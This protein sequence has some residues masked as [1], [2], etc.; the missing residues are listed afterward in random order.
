MAE[1]SPA[2]IRLVQTSW[3]AVLPISDAAASLFYDR[4]FAL[5]PAIRPLF[6]ADLGDQKKKLMQTLNVA[7]SGLNDVGKLVPVL[8][9]LGARHASYMVRE[10]HFGLVGE[11]LL[12]TLRE[13]L[14]D[15]F[16]PAVEAAWT[17]VY[18]IV[19]SVMIGA[20]RRATS[21]TAVDG[22]GTQFPT[23]AASSP[24]RAM[25]FPRPIAATLGSPS[26]RVD[27]PSVEVPAIAPAA[28]RPAAP[29]PAM[30]PGSLR[31]EL[32]P[33]VTSAIV[34]AIRTRPAPERQGPSAWMPRPSEPPA[35][36]APIA[37][38]GAWLATSALV[39]ALGGVAVGAAM[40]PSDA[41]AFARAAPVAM[42]LA[43]VW[44][45]GVWLG[46]HLGAT[47]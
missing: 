37:P 35:P 23:S 17:E 12:W 26:A 39:G 24:Q 9:Q 44:A 29:P 16:T 14:G 7:V 19:S 27:P 32:D 41:T 36:A 28:A 42:A 20:M 10:E 46:R 8:E 4:L 43:A 11:A 6:K 30:V 1:I 13:G 21:A 47:R 3:A 5:D 18:G 40:G 34:E 2:T 45:A 33:A 15:A 22:S 25:P 31:I 38:K